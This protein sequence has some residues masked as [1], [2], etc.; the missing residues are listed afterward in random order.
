MQAASQASFS[1]T[2]TDIGSVSQVFDGQTSTLMRTASINPA[3]VDLAFT[4]SQTLRSFRVFTS[5]PQHR[6]KVQSADTLSDLNGQIGSYAE[7]VP[8]TTTSGD[9]YSAATLASPDSA[10]FLRLT[11]ERLQG[12]DFVHVYEWEVTGDVTIDSLAVTP[13]PVT[14]SQMM[15]TQLT[16]TG[17]SSTGIPYSLTNQVAW[18]STNTSVATV[19]SSGLVSGVTP[20]TSQVRANLGD[21]QGTGQV[22]VTGPEPIDLNV[23]FIGRTPAYN[24]DAAKNNPIVGDLVTFQAHVMNWGGLAVTNAAYRWE[25]DGVSVATGNI[26]NLAARQE[27]VVNLPWTWQA[28]DHNV[29]FIIDP[30][31]QVV[32]ASETNNSISNRING[33]SVGF[34]VEQSIYN[35]FQ[36]HQRDLGIGS[37]SWEDWAQ[38]QMARWNQ[39]SADS[40]STESP[41]GALDRV[42]IDKIIVV[43][44]GALPLHGGLATNNPDLNDKTVDL[45]WGFPSS[46]LQGSLYVDT[47]SVSDSNP[48]YYE[49]SLVH[50][51]GHARYLVDQYG[52]DVHNTSGHASVQILEQG[53]PL[54]GSALMPFLAFGEVLYYNQYGGIMSGPYSGWSPYETSALNQI[55]GQRA[56]AGNYNA[57]GNIGVFLNDLP[58]QNRVQFIDESGVVAAGANVKVFQSTATPGLYAKTFDS[59]PDLQFTADANGQI[60]LPRN[61]FRPGNP[62]INSPEQG[63]LLLRIEWSGKVWFQFME[64]PTFNMEYWRGHTAEGQYVV[65]LPG[66]GNTRTTRDIALKGLDR[67]I[68]RGVTTTSPL[69]GTNLGTISLGSISAPSVFAIANNGAQTLNLTN[70]TITGAAAADFSVDFGN[71]LAIGAGSLLPLKL[72]FSP[73]ATGTRTATVTI[74]SND[75]DEASFS[76]AVSG[77]GFQT[78]DY[79]QNG[80]VDAADYTVWSD[81]LGSTTNLAADGNKNGSIDQGD[82]VVWRA[83]FGQP[84][85]ASGA[86]SGVGATTT[87]APDSALGDDSTVAQASLNKFVYGSSQS[88][89][90]PH[91]G[92]E[93]QVTSRQTIPSIALFPNSSPSA[94]TWSFGRRSLAPE[95]TIAN[96]LSDDAI[97][98]WLASQADALKPTDDVAAGRTIVVESS[99]VSSGL[100]ARFVEHALTLSPMVSSR[101]ASA[102]RLAFD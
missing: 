78:G 36:Q 93:A 2:Q 64:A 92:N 8:W 97:M 102:T 59:T 63:I 5:A 85:P 70:I 37:N 81:S 39:Y 14:V 3:V 80:T 56:S 16:A 48:F 100:D 28:G 12:D 40:V 66:I 89:V 42:R 32:E 49:Q 99:G 69:N 43:P 30:S 25:I 29:T 72:Q 44:D 83:N 55:A 77:I 96:N 52:F 65:E 24:F 35:Y 1:G 87:S 86:G 61:P 21:L 38:S 15:T 13:S 94:S 19:N 84:L 46:L 26:A 82:Y 6:W 53:L 31:N 33:I 88:A 95:R 47:H 91:Q 50:E 57:P 23:T 7:I 67:P 79:N 27:Q 22:T 4:S 71:D 68:T 101:I 90:S 60:L 18:S 98:A 76:F 58:A 11:V 9:Q 74:S 41:F 20:G 51:L 75:P 45:M 54:A 73:Q 34:W 17:T 10:K 62:A